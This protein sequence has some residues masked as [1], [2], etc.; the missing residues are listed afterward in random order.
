MTDKNIVL[1]GFMGSGKTSVGKKISMQLKREFID[2]DDFIVQ[3]VGLSINE[4]FKQHGEQYFRNLEKDLCKR[5]GK[6]K[7]K[8]IATGGGVIKDKKNVDNLRKNG[9]II[10]LQTTPESIAHNLK[11]D[12]SRP[13]LAVGN[14][15]EKIR[16]LMAERTP[17]YEQLADVTIDVANLDLDKTIAKIIQE[18]S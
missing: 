7:Q 5:L 9:I 1:I 8:I 11:N 14:K 2:M 4:I 10:Y 17:L 12:H 15:L 6:A 3:K 13:L 16:E 18:V